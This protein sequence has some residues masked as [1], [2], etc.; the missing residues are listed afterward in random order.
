MLDKHKVG[1]G[2]LYVNKLADVE[3]NVLQELIKEGCENG[4]IGTENHL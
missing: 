4:H 1:K 2:C 3:V